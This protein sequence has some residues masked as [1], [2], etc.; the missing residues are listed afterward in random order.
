M[1]PSDLPQHREAS[2]TEIYTL[3][4]R[5]PSLVYEIETLALHFESSSV[6]TWELLFSLIKSLPVVLLVELCLMPVDLFFSV[7]VTAMVARC[8][9]S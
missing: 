2:T 4:E 6:V 1:R 3:R 8:D 5:G 7:R 9:T